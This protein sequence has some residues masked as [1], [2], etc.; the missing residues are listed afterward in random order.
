MHRN[1]FPYTVSSPLLLLLV[2][3]LLTSFA[4]SL[5]PVDVGHAAP[6][7]QE[8]ACPEGYICIHVNTPLDTKKLTFSSQLSGVRG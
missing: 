7:A 3:A 1:T 6:E 5:W 4:L 2:A 8:S